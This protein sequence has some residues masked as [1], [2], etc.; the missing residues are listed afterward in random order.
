MYQTPKKAKKISFRVIPKI[1]DELLEFYAVLFNHRDKGLLIN[2]KVSF[3]IE[4]LSL[5]LNLK[6]VT[7]TFLLN[8]IAACNTSKQNILAGYLDNII[9]TFDTKSKYF[10]N[11]MLNSALRYYHDFIQPTTKYKIP[12]DND[13]ILL[14]RLDLNIEIMKSQFV[15]TV[16][17]IQNVIF[18]LVKMNPRAMKDCFQSLYKIL[19]GNTTG[20]KIG[21]FFYLY[22]LEKIQNLIRTRLELKKK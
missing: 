4:D 21:G 1:Y 18:D 5:K 20:P 11:Q 8:L 10:F 2:T 3:I 15:V 13:V 7:F 19:L 16:N 14:T 17:R 6:N 12:D 9:S 22:G